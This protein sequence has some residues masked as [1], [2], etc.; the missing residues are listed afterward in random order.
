MG[1]IQRKLLLSSVALA[2]TGFV[3]P[4]A[5]AQDATDAPPAV[6]DEASRELD[7][8]TVTV[9]T[10]TL[11][12][13]VSPVGANVLSI[14]QEAIAE[15]A[16]ASSIDLLARVPQVTNTFNTLPTALGNVGVPF[17]RPN[18]RNLGNAGS[19]TTLTLLNGHR[20]V[21]SGA[22]QSA[23]DVTT[24]APEVLGRL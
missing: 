7:T 3:A 21:G 24:I 2:S 20:L 16:P 10:G 19:D 6:T 4:I 1:N 12:R 14:D 18:I 22:L 11:L 15:I 5:M 23:P 13:G 9:S 17:P 8:V